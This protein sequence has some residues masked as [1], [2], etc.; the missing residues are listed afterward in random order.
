MTTMELIGLAAVLWVSGGALFLSGMVNNPH[1]SPSV[2]ETSRDML[3]GLA[4][5]EPASLVAIA[6]F[7]AVWPAVFL[8][9]QVSKLR[10][11]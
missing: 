4:R 5:C 10:A 1:A 9:A 8:G 6:L 2:A 3:H 11:G 7:I